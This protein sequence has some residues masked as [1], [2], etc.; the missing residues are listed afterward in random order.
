[1]ICTHLEASRKSP[2]QAQVQRGLNAQAGAGTIDTKLAY[3]S[4]IRIAPE[5]L[6]EPL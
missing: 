4:S 2:Q 5:F 3:L 1:M 6:L